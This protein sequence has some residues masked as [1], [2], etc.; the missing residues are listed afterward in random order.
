[1]GSGV[2]LVTLAMG[3]IAGGERVYFAGDYGFRLRPD[4]LHCH[5]SYRE[6]EMLANASDSR[7]AWERLYLRGFRY[8][9][10]DR[11]SHQPM[12]RVLDPARV[13]AWDLVKAS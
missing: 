11:S 12:L 1:M 5:C 10:I 9:V 2:R 13:P 6:E 8:A 3:K 7:T 4:I